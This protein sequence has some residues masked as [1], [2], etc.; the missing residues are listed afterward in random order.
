LKG[1][2]A[3]VTESVED[4]ERAS[5]EESE[6]DSEDSADDV[7]D[8][9]DDDVGNDW[10]DDVE[11]EEEPEEVTPSMNSFPV[12]THTA[13]PKRGRHSDGNQRNRGGLVNTEER[14]L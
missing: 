12:P 13:K 7:D 6:D 5:A 1:I 11:D 3:N 10:E 4:E 2:I 8:D 14:C 9:V